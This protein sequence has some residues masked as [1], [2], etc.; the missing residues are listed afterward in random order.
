MSS[1]ASVR[2]VD[3][4]QV[5]KTFEGEHGSVRAL[6]GISFRVGQGERLGILGPNGSGKSTLIKILS[7]ILV[8]TS[9]EVR[10]GL[11]LSWP[12]ALGGGFEGQLTGA[13]NVR[14]LCRLYGL[15]IKET[16]DYVKDFSE[17]GRHLFMPVRF[18]S[19]GMRMRLAFALS[20]AMDFE[21]Y[22]I[23][24]V[25][26]VGDRRFQIKCH[27]ELFGRRAHCGM[28]MAVHDSGIVKEYCQSALIMKNGRGR[29]VEDVAVAG[30]I[31]GAL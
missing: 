4:I 30:R 3:V 17:L 29:I 23:D 18:Y 12:L 8:P 25:I 19:D 26:L 15:P 14:F 13:D 27:D 16:T 28:I 6:D 11:R 24:E 1:D 2:C 31:Y 9:G 5:T 20:L 21:C 22:L 10:R 7:G